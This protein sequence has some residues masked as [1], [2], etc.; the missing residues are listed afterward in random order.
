MFGILGVEILVFGAVL[1]GGYALVRSGLA[2]PALVSEQV[3]VRAA[4]ARSL[5]LTRRRTMRT[6]GS[7]TRYAR[8]AASRSG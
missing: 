6:D 1:L 4:L 2:I 3:G 8:D 5:E 7:P